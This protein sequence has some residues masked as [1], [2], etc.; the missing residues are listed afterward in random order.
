AKLLDM[1]QKA[2]NMKTAKD[3]LSLETQET[4]EE[5]ENNIIQ[6]STFEEELDSDNE[7]Y[8]DTN[9]EEIEFDTN[10][11]SEDWEQF[12]SLTNSVSNM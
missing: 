7:S 11:N 8:K 6:G 3:G 4:I 9:K 10:F 5:V 1:E 12:Q 2:A